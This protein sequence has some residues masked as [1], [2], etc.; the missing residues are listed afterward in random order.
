MAVLPFRKKNLI[1]FGAEH[2]DSS[3]TGGCKP[4]WQLNLQDELITSFGVA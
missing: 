1:K 4:N 3:S 2:Q